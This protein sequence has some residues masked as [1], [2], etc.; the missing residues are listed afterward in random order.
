M[1]PLNLTL[2]SYGIVI[3]IVVL[4]SILLILKS[5][6]KVRTSFRLGKSST[7]YSKII[8]EKWL[9]DHIDELPEGQYSAADKNGFICS[10]PG[11]TQ[12]MAELS[13]KRVSLSEVAIKFKD[14]PEES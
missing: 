4:A 7:S 9:E 5:R 3:L 14:K 8:G 11:L 10:S 2:A 13:L 6:N 1:E 12:L